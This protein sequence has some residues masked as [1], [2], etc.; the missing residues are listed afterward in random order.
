MGPGTACTPAAEAKEAQLQ[1]MAASE[2][3]DRFRCPLY[4]TTFRLSKGLVASDKVAVE[5]FEL[6]TEELP[7]KWAK[8][9]VALIMEVDRGD[10]AA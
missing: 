8:R 9:A 7:R 10:L 4:Q 1:E 6:R 3:L 2:A 5:Y